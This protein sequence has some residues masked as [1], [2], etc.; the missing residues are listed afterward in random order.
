LALHK[1][2][3]AKRRILAVLCRRAV[4][5]CASAAAALGG[6]TKHPIGFPEDLAMTQ[7][8]RIEERL[9]AVDDRTRAKQ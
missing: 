8:D 9:Q 5:G 7:L 6:I 3:T 4:R 2:I 1:L